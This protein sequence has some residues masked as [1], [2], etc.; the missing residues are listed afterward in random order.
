MTTSPNPTPV[1]RENPSPGAPACGRR[2]PGW[3]TSRESF[4]GI[5]SND[6]DPANL[7]DE[8]DR[9]WPG[10]SCRFPR[11]NAMS[12][13][14]SSPGDGRPCGRVILHD[15]YQDA[16]NLTFHTATRK[17]AEG[18]VVTKRW[19]WVDALVCL[20]PF[21]ARSTAYEENNYAS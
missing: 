16:H 10:S 13:R 4:R 21:A 11:I 18:E 12:L 5:D 2:S 17:R 9:K 7:S 20:C 8:S 6:V 3:A 1:V 15:P 19:F 14:R